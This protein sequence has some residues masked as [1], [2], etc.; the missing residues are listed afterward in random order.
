MHT[1]AVGAACTHSLLVLS[2]GQGGGKCRR[3]SRGRQTFLQKV[4]KISAQGRA[5][6]A[7]AHECTT[8]DVL[9]PSLPQ[10]AVKHV[11]PIVC[12]KHGLASC[13]AVSP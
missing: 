8:H 2:R 7:L 4:R 5:A 6:R 3:T 9:H 10:L 12:G 11:L 1:A 13:A